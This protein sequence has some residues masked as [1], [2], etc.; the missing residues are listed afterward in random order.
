MIL[1][2]C[3]TEGGGGGSS[4][5]EGVVPGAGWPAGARCVI[6]V[7]KTIIVIIFV[8]MSKTFWVKN[9][10]SIII[11]FLFR[12]GIACLGGRVSWLYWRL[13]MMGDVEKDEE[14]CWRRRESLGRVLRV[15]LRCWRA[16]M[17]A[18]ADQMVDGEEPCLVAV[19]SF[20]SW[21]WWRWWWWRG[22]ASLQFT[23][24]HHGDDDDDTRTNQ[25][26]VLNC[27]SAKKVNEESKS[28][29]YLPPPFLQIPL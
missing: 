6:V 17:S 25:P 28:S 16:K 2:I 9:R 24:I 27:A 14:E 8:V 21:G 22:L 5:S 4:V 26:S 29:P 15:D 7:I 19:S 10:S 18:S 23:I 20:P 13:Q 3:S 1:N 12:V 11:F